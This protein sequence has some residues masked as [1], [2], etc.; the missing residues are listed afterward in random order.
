MKLSVKRISSMDIGALREMSVDFVDETPMPYPTMDKSEIDKHMFEVLSNKDN[1]DYIGLI[2]YDGKKPAG[3]LIGWVVDK[4]YTQP[5]VVPEKR[6]GI[7]GL[8][9]MEEA[10]RLAVE[11]GAKG[12]ECAGTYQGTDKRWEKFGF[13]PFLT[14]GY[15][16]PKDFMD[17][18]TRFTRGRTKAA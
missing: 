2:A 3:F 15:M 12:F 10:G 1:P 8:K 14:Y 13:K 5:D 18:V 7:V 4:P 16:D 9:L 6:A 17:L 11:R